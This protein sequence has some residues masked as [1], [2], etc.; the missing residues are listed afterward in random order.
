MPLDAPG[1]GNGGPPRAETEGFPPNH[2]FYFFIC[3]N[4]HTHTH[5]WEVGHG[6]DP[7][8]LE[9]EAQGLNGH[10]MVLGEGLVLEDPHQ[11]TDG[12]GRVEVLQ[13]GPTAHGHQQLTGCV[14]CA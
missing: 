1:G 12:Y 7:E 6:L 8:A 9:D 5:L 13:T 3:N 2:H 4:P 11:G 14:S 10:G